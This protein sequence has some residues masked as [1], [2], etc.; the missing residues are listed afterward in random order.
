MK[1][2]GLFFLAVQSSLFCNPSHSL[3][4]TAPVPEAVGTIE[5]Q[6]IFANSTDC[7]PNTLE[8]DIKPYF[9]SYG[10]PLSYCLSN[11]YIEG[12]VSNL[13]VTLDP[14]HGM[15]HIPLGWFGVNTTIHLQFVGKNPYGSA[16]QHMRV[17]LEPCGG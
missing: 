7:G 6:M 16:M 14:Y 11:I 3:Q 12:D 5:D 9:N 2:L 8:F 13:N 15:L 17:F 1:K 10:E 4:R